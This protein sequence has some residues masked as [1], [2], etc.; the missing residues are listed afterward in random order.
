MGKRGKLVHDLLAVVVAVCLCATMMPL[1]A[2]A[3][4]SETETPITETQGTEGSSTEN[5]SGEFGDIPVVTSLEDEEG[6]GFTD[7]TDEPSGT[8]GDEPSEEPADDESPSGTEDPEEPAVE[9]EGFEG[10]GEEPAAIALFDDEIEI[11]AEETHEPTNANTVAMIGAD[12]FTSLQDAIDAAKN[13]DK[14]IL[15][16]DSQANLNIDAKSITIDLNGFDIVK[17]YNYSNT[18]EASIVSITNGSNVV[19]SGTGYISGGG[20]ASRLSGN[21][22]K[23]EKYR[24]ITATTSNVTIDGPTVVGVPTS[25][26]YAMY[27]S[28]DK[29]YGGAVYINEGDFE[30]KAGEVRGG[31]SGS[32]SGVRY[33][34]V[35]AIKNGS[36]KM[37][38]GK[39]ET[40]G[41]KNSS[42][43]S[44]AAVYVTGKSDGSSKAEILG[45]TINCTRASLYTKVS[46]GG[47]LYISNCHTTISGD[48]KILNGR[49]TTAGGNIYVNA[50]SLDIYGGKIAD[51]LVSGSAASGFDGGGGIYA[52]NVPTK[53]SGGEITNNTT[54]ST[55]GAGVRFYGTGAV[56]EM[57][58]G[59]V[60]G[61]KAGA[62]GAKG[63]GGGIHINPT[64]DNTQ[65]TLG[66][67]IKGNV[68]VPAESIGGGVYIETTRSNTSVKI[69]DALITENNAGYGGGLAFKS[70]NNNPA[71]F[72]LSSETRIFK[73][74]A[75]QEANNV[76][77]TTTNKTDELFFNYASKVSFYRD[78]EKV[79]NYEGLAIPLGLTEFVYE[80]AKNADIAGTLTRSNAVAYYGHEEVNIT[81]DDCVDAIILDP[82]GV[83]EHYVWDEEAEEPR[84]AL[85]GIDVFT[86]ID[87]AINAS[88]ESG[89]SIQ[90]CSSALLQDEVNGYADEGVVFERCRHHIDTELFLVQKSASLSNIRI[91]GKGISSTKALIYVSAASLALNQGVEIEN[92]NRVSKGNGGA[93]QLNGDNGST[94]LSID[95]GAI[96]R[97]NSCGSVT[98][99][100]SG[101]AIYSWKGTIEVKNGIFTGNHAFGNGGAICGEIS[102]LK[103]GYGKREIG[104]TFDSNIAG[105]RGGAVMLGGISTNVGFY[106]SYG[107]INRGTF[108]SNEA[109]ADEQNDPYGGG[110]I[111]N[112]PGCKLYMK[113][114]LVTENEWSGPASYSQGFEAAVAN[115]P[116]ASLDVYEQDG[117]LIYGNYSEKGLLGYAIQTD[118]SYRT[119]KGQEAFVSEIAL[120]GGECGWTDANGGV[121]EKEYYQHTKEFFR[122]VGN[123]SEQAIALG[124][125]QAQVVFKYNKSVRSG[126]AIG[127][128]GSLTIGTQ[129]KSLTVTKTWKD[130]N[131]NPIDEELVPE[132]VKVTL[133]YKN[134]DGVVVPVDEETRNDSVQYL[135]AS[136]EEDENWTY[137]WNKLAY[138]IEW[139]VIEE[140]VPGY[141]S[142]ISLADRS[143]SSGEKPI[144]RKTLN[145]E[146]KWAPNAEKPER[147]SVTLAY[148]DDG[149]VTAA[150]EVRGDAEKVLNEQNGWKIA[151]VDLDP[152]KNWLV[153]EAADQGLDVAIEDGSLDPENSQECGDVK[154]NMIV[155]NAWNNDRTNIS[156]EKWWDDQD[157]FYNIQPDSIELTLKTDDGAID[158][159]GNGR[160]DESEYVPMPKMPVTVEPNEDGDWH[161]DFIDLPKYTKKGEEIQYLIVESP[162]A[163]YVSKVEP[164][165]TGQKPVLDE[166]GEQVTD[167]EGNLVFENVYTWSIMPIADGDED[168][169]D[170]AVQEWCAF[171][172]TNSLEFGELKIAKELKRTGPVYNMTNGQGS[173][174]AVF[175]VVGTWG[176]GDDVKTIYDNY[177]ALDFTQPDT[178]DVTLKDM[179]V[180]ATYTVTEMPFDGSGYEVVGNRSITK[181]LNGDEDTGF[182]FSFVN[183]GDN[184]EHPNVG[185]VNHY[186]YDAETQSI[187]RV[188]V[189]QLAIETVHELVNA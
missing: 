13:G 66:G 93:I 59:I 74:H 47:N 88:K 6:E 145:V 19:F 176:E 138:G 9:G 94:F 178:K 43:G 82:K 106:P 189:V 132:K 1:L 153:I 136:E 116:T 55:S 159:N 157:N 183:E 107:Y 170:A 121:P 12:E 104:G 33:G 17:R 14:I 75:T 38:G 152:D 131:G 86:S 169:E 133:A 61:N 7:P 57:T 58:G 11:Q 154:E 146:K 20:V 128:N 130:E 16:K 163:G 123:P 111:Y 54:N 103:I 96:L 36:F 31:I 184:E 70:G 135:S 142:I 2:T 97:N 119:T 117:A 148:E 62:N 155:T 53:I 134:S 177:V 173:Y 113:N 41:L 67:T 92:A 76:S 18:G 64:L 162:V 89:K 118:I 44:G 39:I 150:N 179:I 69:G 63:N 46:T 115:C 84:Q 49:A 125:S 188:N 52:S 5:P 51:G 48:A 139:T 81:R 124:A 78:G 83:S 87:E 186:K 21:A 3:D 80:I 35:I 161:Y 185:I 71:E 22:T 181:P 10:A 29:L 90:V 171:N 99:K 28:L 68:A 109:H 165:V 32:T 166:N 100:L 182:V 45:G 23:N 15:H 26:S 102:T 164:V 127:N 8:E 108:Q 143:S 91:D 101:G 180:G 42:S 156:A 114:V 149:K 50:G 168:L 122:L 126:S 24:I 144:V 79:V 120:G 37:S 73:N 187:T 77:G 72:D 140:A 110:A 65:I 56:F 172:I 158:A 175:H 85:D 25:S 147:I 30:L 4:P 105:M 40:P 129:T 141:E 60:S 98:D 137:T 95:G 174:T 112:S 151:W 167:E 160:I 27:E 34:G